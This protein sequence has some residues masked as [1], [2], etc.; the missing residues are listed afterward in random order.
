MPRKR[1]HYPPRSHQ[2]QQPKPAQVRWPQF[3]VVAVVL[4]LV[5][6][7][8]FLKSRDADRPTV[9]ASQ[10][11]ATGS[12]IAAEGQA[13]AT[14]AEGQAPATAALN[15]EQLAVPPA[16]QPNEL[17]GAQLDR[18][19]AAKQPTLA[20]FHSNNCKQ[21]LTMM[22]V[23]EQ[24]YPEF[25]NSVALVDV[26]VYDERNAAL[27]QRARI[28]AIPTQIFFDRSGQ[29]RVV[30]GAMEPEQLRQELQTLV[31]AP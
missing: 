12:P 14:A 8:F 21:C 3:A 11:I 7:V 30:L 17:P 28:R 29:G 25:A 2:S 6:L 31:G 4:I 23:V 27:L 5:G 18:L 9:A 19:L 16:A 24:V 1:H 20:F 26:N 22:E 10:S 13:P 15:H